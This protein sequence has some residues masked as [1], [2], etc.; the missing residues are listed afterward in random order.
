[1]QLLC[2]SLVCVSVEYPVLVTL[3][4]CCPRVFRHTKNKEIVLVLIQHVWLSCC[5]SKW[6]ARSLSAEGLLDQVGQLQRG[7]REEW[8]SNLSLS[9]ETKM[10]VNLT[11]FARLWMQ[12]ATRVKQ[13]KRR[14]DPG[15]TW[16]QQ[17]GVN[18]NKGRGWKVTLVSRRESYL[19]FLC[20]VLSQEY[21]H[22]WVRGA[23][24]C[25]WSK[26][27]IKHKRRLIMITSKEA[28]HL[29]W[30]LGCNVACILVLNRYVRQAV[31]LKG[32]NQAPGQNFLMIGIRSVA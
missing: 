7:E 4:Q 10:T 11:G 32:A 8:A 22:P 31:D 3:V 28:D 17:W 27:T 6:L 14:M 16:G 13:N 19:S 1:V 15:R 5:W 23:Y 24:R 2:I 29:Y 12:Q 25:Q 20:I 26:A 18:N 9:L 30:Q 21:G